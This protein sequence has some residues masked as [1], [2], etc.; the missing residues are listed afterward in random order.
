MI[1]SLDDYRARASAP[2]H[3]CPVCLRRVLAREA[4]RRSHREAC[5]SGELDLDLLHCPTCGLVLA[6]EVE[7][8]Q[9]AATHGAAAA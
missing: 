7:P 8:G 9:A 5:R 3:Y 1:V 4:D 2:G 6:A